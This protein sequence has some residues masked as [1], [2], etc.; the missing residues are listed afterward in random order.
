MRLPGILLPPPAAATTLLLL[1]ACGS[2]P[3]SGELPSSGDSSDAAVP[4]VSPTPDAAGC[5]GSAPL[6]AQTC[7]GDA[8]FGQARCEGLR[9]VCD[10]GTLETDC[11]RGTCWGAPLP[12]EVCDGGYV[13]RPWETGALAGCP[14]GAML[15]ADCRG[16]GDEDVEA[17]GCTCRCEGGSIFCR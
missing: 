6:C 15:C 9:W 12:G 16:F 14:D 7:G 17:E 1:A 2:T 4:D 13:C 11:P 5:E 3:G 8:F 10:E